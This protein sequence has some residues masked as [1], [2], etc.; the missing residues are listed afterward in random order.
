MENKDYSEILRAQLNV[1]AKFQGRAQ[2]TL[3]CMAMCSIPGVKVTDWT[4][5]NAFCENMAKQIDAELKQEL[6]NLK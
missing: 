5:F 1:Y 3:A 2:G 4:A 6:K